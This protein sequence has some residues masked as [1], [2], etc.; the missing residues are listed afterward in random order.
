MFQIERKECINK[1]PDWE[2][3]SWNIENIDDLNEIFDE[4]PTFNEPINNWNVS[5]VTSMSGMF[6]DCR[7]FNQ[8]LNDWDVGKVYICDMSQMALIAINLI[9]H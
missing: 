3:N 2:L 9:N 6:K 1:Y 7:E 5:N 4:F 8:P